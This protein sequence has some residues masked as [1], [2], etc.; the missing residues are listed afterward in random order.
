M[1]EQS[2]GL[3]FYL[4]KPKGFNAGEAP[5]YLRITVDGIAAELSTK[6]KCNP[7]KWNQHAE[8]AAGN[9]DAIKSLNA[10]LET[11]QQ[12]VHEIKRKLIEHDKVISAETIKNI[13]I[14]KQDVHDSPRMLLEIFQ[15]HNDQIAALVGKGYAAGT[16]ERYIT[17]FKHTRAF[18]EW[19][20]KISD[21]DIRKL[22]YEFIT[23]YEFWIKSVRS[24]D[25]NT[26]MKYLA[27]F[28]KIVKRCLKNGWLS[29][30]PFTGFSMT[31][32][33][34]ERQAL[35][36]EELDALRNK[37]FTIDRLNQVRDIFIFSCYTGLAYADVQK[38]KR[39]EISIGIDGGKWIFANRKKTNS[40]SRIPLLPKAI[41]I[42][43]HYSEHPQCLLTD[44]VLPVLSNQK[45]NSYLKE[46]ADLCGICKN[47][48][49]HIARHT[50]ATTITL[51]NGVPI[52]TVSKMLGHK[53]LRT[54]QHYA[55]I[56]DH[57]IS[58]DMKGLMEKHI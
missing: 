13:L 23:E 4:K 27:N 45:M 39:S 43:N 15:H 12:K 19:K 3:L 46:I 44:K 48:T 49:Y 29:R 33:E 37:K 17:S 14:G 24:C 22:N 35:S 47:L 41:E 6:R 7:L 26:T 38:L 31:K 1:I 34:V 30:D 56:L 51:S 50:F 9:K 28:R 55:K 16:L 5:I 25:H 10:Y 20:Y 36:V 58:Q 52:E 54:T 11:I 42:L 21:I 2:F 57:K 8:R 53:N 32:K 18:L 40:L